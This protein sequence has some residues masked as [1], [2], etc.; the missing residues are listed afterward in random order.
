VTRARGRWEG[1]RIVAL[2]GAALVAMTLALLG[3]AGFGEEGVRA[4]I[5]ATARTSLVLFAAT[6]SASSLQ[7]LL[8]APATAWLLRNRRYLGLS[9]AASHA[10]HLAAI[11]ALAFGWPS[12]YDQVPTTTRVGGTLGFVAI[13]VLAATSND[14]SVAWLGA[15]RWRAIH[16]AGGWL[17]WV[18]FAA[19]YLPA[20][21][22]PSRTVYAGLVAAI[23]GV[24]A[25]AWGRSRATRPHGATAR[26][27]SPTSSSVGQ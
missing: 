13:A 4:V 12:D 18:I 9:F 24:R 1:P 20:I 17:L 15:R 6:F 3:A 16:R 27:S 5:R 26:S 23:A 2:A 10:I 11:L 22:D 7:G 19:S 21:G 8:R 25:A 14:R